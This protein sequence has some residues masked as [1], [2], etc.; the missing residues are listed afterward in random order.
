MHLKISAKIIFCFDLKLSCSEPSSIANVCKNANKVSCYIKGKEVTD[1]LKDY[2]LLKNDSA[3]QSE[4]KSNMKVQ[5]YT[6]LENFPHSALK[7]QTLLLNLIE[8]FLTAV[9]ET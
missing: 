4:L 8:H 2:K 1:Q 7:L 9:A 3:P 5:V 6:A